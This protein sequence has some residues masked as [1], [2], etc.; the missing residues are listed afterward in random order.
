MDGVPGTEVKDE[1]IGMASRR[2]ELE[3]QLKTATDPPPLLHPSM[4]YL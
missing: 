4:A 3:P 1:L 2:E